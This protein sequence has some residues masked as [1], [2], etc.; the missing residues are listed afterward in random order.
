MVFTGSPRGI[1]PRLARG[2]CSPTPLL[3]GATPRGPGRSVFAQPH[4]VTPQADNQ[5]KIEQAVNKIQDAADKLKDM[6]KDLT[7]GSSGRSV[8]NERKLKATPTCP[9]AQLPTPARSLATSVVRTSSWVP[10]GPVAPPASFVLPVA[11][12]CRTQSQS[13]IAQAR[14]PV[15]APQEQLGLTV[16]ARCVASHPSSGLA[17]MAVAAVSAT[18]DEAKAGFK[19]KINAVKAALEEVENLVD[20]I[21]S[22]PKATPRRSSYHA[23]VA[24][25]PRSGPPRQARVPS[26]IA[27]APANG[28]TILAPVA[29]VQ[30]E[31]MPLV[32][33]A[34]RHAAA[35]NA[36][37]A[38]SSSYNPP[39][40]DV[41]R[42]ALAVPLTGRSSH[43]PTA[44][45]VGHFASG[46]HNARSVSPPRR[47]ASAVVNATPISW[48]GGST[49]ISNC[50]MHH[51]LGSHR[52]VSQNAGASQT[53]AAHRFPSPHVSG[54]AI[55]RGTGAFSF[56]SS[57]D[58][59]GTAPRKQASQES[60]PPPAVEKEGRMKPKEELHISI[61]SA[62][63]AEIR[64]RISPSASTCSPRAPQTA[65][66]MPMEK[67]HPR[68]F[69]SEPRESTADAGYG[70]EC[71][72]LPSPHHYE[73]HPLPPFADARYGYGGSCTSL[74][75]SLRT[76]VAAVHENVTEPS[77][78]DE[79][80]DAPLP[81]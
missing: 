45:V 54:R 22:T 51:L 26:G 23:G 68:L 11:A 1:S 50:H 58:S 27:T 19:K 30:T 6:Q 38:S 53:S 4:G 28:S 3:E 72:R 46:Y 74:G 20:N 62:E 59:G 52:M 17:A 77:K 9:I 55:V 29:K 61:P 36:L 33:V 81:N 75:N 66:L 47:I 35:T 41:A 42:E 56:G 14:S 71:A 18:E 65:R 32:P 7:E 49:G 12:S 70:F 15:S 21:S 63:E 44:Q 34:V 13:P 79:R 40:A 73:N 24:L 60:L 64:D 8:T 80:H 78:A 67:A 39:L 2:R 10:Q 37:G 76:T 16:A 57:L 69:E 43:P 48:A 25:Q 5:N 31:A